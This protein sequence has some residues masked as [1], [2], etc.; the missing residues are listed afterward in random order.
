MATDTTQLQGEVNNEP[1]ADVKDVERL[2]A[3]FLK[4]LLDEQD[5]RRPS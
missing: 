3:G 2:L 1:E 5:V 4:A